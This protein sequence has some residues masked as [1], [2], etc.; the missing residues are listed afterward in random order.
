[1]SVFVIF[2]FAAII[3][4][5]GLMLAPALPTHQPRIGLAATLALGIVVVATIGYTALFKWD[6]L[7]IDY[8]WFGL[9]VVVF[10]TG[11]FSAGMFKA[12][13]AG[14]KETGWPGPRELAFFLMAAILFATPA[15]ILPVPLDTDAQGFGYLALLLRDGG[16]LTTLA[17]Y[18][19]EISY[20]YSP[21]FTA[22]VAYLSHALHAGLGNIQLAV[23]GT[24]SVLFIWLAYD[25]GSEID[26]ARTRRTGIAMAVCALLGA[27]LLMAD[28][29]SHYTALLALIFA[30]AALTFAVR[31][32]NYGKRIDLIGAA[33]TLACVPLSHPDTTIIL[34]LGYVPWLLVMWFAR[35]RPAVTRWLGLAVGIPGLAL[36]LIA[37]WLSR[38]APLLNSSIQ[39]PFEIS[40]RHLIVLFVY[41]GGLIVLLAIG[42][43]V[44]GLRRRNAVDLLMIVWLALIIDFSSIGLLQRLAPG[45]LSPLLKYDY[46]FSIAWHGPIIP[47]AYLGAQAL[48]WLVDRVGRARADLWIKRLSLP[49]INLI[50]LICLLI[51][52]FAGQFIDLTR[53]TPLAIFGAF[54]S[55][56]DI[57]A[58][59]WINQN[60]P[61]NALIL[62]HPGPQEGDWAPVIAQR[63]TVYFRPQPFFTNTEEAEARQR[64]LLP[65]WHNPADPANA[66][67]LA[68]YNVS[69][70]LVPQIVVKPG[71]FKTMFRWRPP[72]PDA[73][74]NVDVASAPYLKL[75]YDSDGAQV[76]QV[77]TSQ[78]AKP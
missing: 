78:A 24:L 18:H 32:L 76:Y 36:L 44:L 15:L 26:P 45:P 43:V 1:M 51:I 62:N 9:I 5:A 2:V 35:P 16:S 39:S 27:G 58:M 17:P 72:S 59:Q 63:D 38:I 19:P 73:I 56:A 12:E 14:K 41:H 10:L 20:L 29:D 66:E 21:G 11:T 49:I 50:A 48:L 40:P 13:A 4:G 34:I 74:L 75:V 67:L 57:Q 46:P 52:A 31:W 53:H 60:T 25:F 61:S 28:L 55:H 7:I 22:L 69:Y 77:N 8:L 6:T 71:T 65:F 37:P 30:L 3:F 33:L 54:S 23:G 64:A 68:H 70:V 47:Y 42:G